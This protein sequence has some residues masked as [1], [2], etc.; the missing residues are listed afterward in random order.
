MR[1]SQ[2]ERLPHKRHIV[3]VVVAVLLVFAAAA[4]AVVAGVV[5]VV[6]SCCRCALLAVRCQ[7]LLTA[8][9]G[10]GLGLS[11]LFA[12]P[13]QNTFKSRNTHAAPQMNYLQ[14]C[15]ISL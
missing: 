1:R 12:L 5:V 10:L 14:H 15:E 11:A 2:Q 8:S 7:R 3:V 6:Q 4:A 9:P 13:K